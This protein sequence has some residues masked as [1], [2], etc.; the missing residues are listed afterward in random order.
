MRLN[1]LGGIRDVYRFGNTAWWYGVG[2]AN[3]L[4]DYDLGVPN[5]V[6]IH[7][8]A[9]M[10]V[11]RYMDGRINVIDRARNDWYRGDEVIGRT[12]GAAAGIADNYGERLTLTFRDKDNNIPVDSTRVSL[13]IVDLAPN[14][15]VRAA[16][17]Y[18]GA[19]LDNEVK[20][21]SA[22]DL[23]NGVA[24]IE[25]NPL[26]G[27]SIT[28]VVVGTQ[29]KPGANNHFALGTNIGL[30]EGGAGGELSLSR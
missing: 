22:N 20:V 9:Q 18:D 6:N 5:H 25:A 13:P 7:D 12:Q 19:V 28:R 16:V 10:A 27:H 2:G 8:A 26:Y 11:V 14:T 23:D 30:G 17:F 1:C 29:D 21:F 4:N 3:G 24:H 15:Q